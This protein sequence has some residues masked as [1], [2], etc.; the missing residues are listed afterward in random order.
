LTLVSLEG[1]PYAMGIA[2]DVL[3]LDDYSAGEERVGTHVVEFQQ[4]LTIG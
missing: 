3:N 2:A 1:Q 4:F